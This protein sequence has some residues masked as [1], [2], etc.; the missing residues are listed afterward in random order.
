MPDDKDPKDGQLTPGGEGDA[1]EGDKS[2]S[3]TYVK[4]IRQ[5][6]AK[7]RT[8]AREMQTKL[9][10]LSAK[11]DGFDL[12]EYEALKAA[13]A[14]AAQEKMEKQG[15]WEKLKEKM[16]ADHAAEVKKYGEQIT[17]REGRYVAL[18]AKLHQTIL[19]NA[20]SLEAATAKAI[21]PRLVQMAIVAEAKVEALDDG[22]EVIRLYDEAGDVRVN[23]KTGEPL[24]IRERI[25]EM[26]QSVEYAHLFE[27]AK[28]GGGSGSVFSNGKPDLSKMTPME[29]LKWERTQMFNGV[30][31]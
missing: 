8:K 13:Q 27:G 11:L 12:D 28:P 15:E 23:P 14:K 5:E 29:K 4:G 19:D 3:E 17:E 20:I 9:D 7:Y 22:R 10:E 2:Y 30:K 25:A 6:A 21:N 26:K 16:V 1:G 18:E 31:G 24:T